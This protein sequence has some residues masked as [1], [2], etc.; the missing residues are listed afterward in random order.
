MTAPWLQ[1]GSGRAF[2]L[3]DP[4]PGSID[5]GVD[6]AE[7]LARIPR[8]TGHVRAGAYSVAQH[9]VLG[10]EMLFAETGRAD[11]AAAFLLHDAHEAYLGDI[12][13]PIVVALDAVQAER[14]RIAGTM[15]PAAAIRILKARLDAVIHAAAGIA[16]PLPEEVTK[17]VKLWD[18]RMLIT[19]RNHL[20]ARPPEPWA[21]EHLEPIVMRGG[22]KVW[23]WPHA[24]DQ[25]LSCLRQW[26]P[27]ALD[28]ARP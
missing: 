23:S 18:A 14:G 1:T 24:A 16:W 7:A 13:S 27:A 5:F 8:F 4:K 11:L 21:L 6:V 15:S 9:C 28:G 2:D 25:Y 12:A 3:T 19:E 22:I 26:C 20:M 17:T 10:A